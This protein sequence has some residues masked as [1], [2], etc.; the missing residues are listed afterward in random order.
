MAKK[1]LTLN[2]F[3]GGINTNKD[4]SDIKSEGRG[5]DECY[6]ATRFLLDQPG[7]ITTITPVANNINYTN[8]SINSTDLSGDD[9]EFGIYSSTTIV[10]DNTIWNYQGVFASGEYINWS[11]NSDFIINKPTEGELKT[12]VGD[13]E[14]KNDGHDLNISVSK[15]GDITLFQD[16]NSPYNPFSTGLIFT[17]VD[18]ADNNST[19]SSG[20]DTGRYC[21]AFFAQFGDGAVDGNDGKFGYENDWWFHD[22]W[23][24]EPT[25][26]TDSEDLDAWQ[27]GTGLLTTNYNATFPQ[28]H[29]YFTDGNAE[30]LTT[31]A[32]KD[33]TEF[34]EFGF[35]HDVSS[36]NSTN[37]LRDT[38]ALYFRTGLKEIDRD[39]DGT[40]PNG[41]TQTGAYSY[42]LSCPDD[43]GPAIDIWCQS[44]V[45]LDRVLVGFD[46]HVYDNE[47]HY[48]NDMGNN[49]GYMKV[50]AFT[51]E[52]LENAGASDGWSRVSLKSNMATFTGSNYN[53]NE[54]R[55][56]FIIPMWSSAKVKSRDLPGSGS[57]SAAHTLAGCQIRVRELTFQKDRDFQTIWEGNDWRFSLTKKQKD[58]ES[59]RMLYADK[60]VGS[61]HAIILNVGKC[62]TE[63]YDSKLYYEKLDREGNVI[64][65]PYLMLEMN[66]NDGV[67][68][69]GEEDWTAWSGNTAEII[70]EKPPIYSNYWI[71]SGYMEGVEEINARWKFA[72][73]CGSQTYIGNVQQPIDNDVSMTEWNNGKILKTTIGTPGGFADNNY[74]DLELGGDYITHMLS[75]GD[76]LFI[77]TRAKLIV[78]NVAQETEFL[79]DE[80][81]GYGVS[82]PG[83]VAEMDN[84][85]AFINGA[86]PHIF[87]ERTGFEYIG[88]QLSSQTYWNP[89]T[90]RVLWEPIR[91]N[92][93]FFPYANP[94]LLYNIDL[95]SWV[96]YDHTGLGLNFGDGWPRGNGSIVARYGSVNSERVPAMYCLYN[97]SYSGTD[98]WKFLNYAG[99][100]VITQTEFGSGKIRFFRTGLIDCGNIAARKKFYKIYINLARPPGYLGEGEID[101]GEGEQNYTVPDDALWGGNFGHTDPIDNTFTGNIGDGDGSDEVQ[102]DVDDKIIGD[103]LGE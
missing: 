63:D 68:K 69:V 14:T 7:K 26:G 35:H 84:G 28:W 20:A 78:I 56:V 92:L 93:F 98:N 102:N 81:K 47:V 57:G 37:T 58:I 6:E 10:K 60:W 41:N 43:Y 42:G 49:D 52:Q 19:F 89:G 91:R 70:F 54:I 65:D 73:T 25:A 82:G 50:W 12:N 79:E 24:T 23:E 61:S 72:A 67:K 76:R 64:G 15:V 34:Q 74:I 36:P 86:G 46:C 18:N 90:A 75:Q 100:N 51:K 16:K 66:E 45:G 94:I 22:T 62:Q 83:Q 71:E 55:G 48:A 13:I 39:E 3:I 103:A 80:F 33:F 21:R 32:V 29:C 44:V 96:Y 31:T 101:E 27:R 88:R 95:K 40:D 4:L 11:N 97:D 8:L 53:A 5:E 77:F 9:N 99:K 59:L 17:D 38:T 30:A 2:G 1:S 87:T 85:F